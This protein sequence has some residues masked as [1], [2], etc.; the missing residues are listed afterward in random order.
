MDHTLQE[1]NIIK[2]EFRI[3]QDAVS[4]L[5]SIHCILSKM[6]KCYFKY[7]VSAIIRKRANFYTCTRGNWFVT[8]VQRSGIQKG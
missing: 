6:L 4:S 3:F 1:V 2:I 7:N 8:S 5:R